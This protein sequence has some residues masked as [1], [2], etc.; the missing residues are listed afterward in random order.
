MKIFIERWDN[1]EFSIKLPTRWFITTLVF[2]G[3][4]KFF[5]IVYITDYTGKGYTVPT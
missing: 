4:N 2:R 1:I 3:S 5:N